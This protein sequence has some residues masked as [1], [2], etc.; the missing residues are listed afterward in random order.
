MEK[1]S[2]L[3]QAFFLRKFKFPHNFPTLQAQVWKPH[4]SSS[5]VD[6]ALSL[7]CKSKA[8]QIGPRRTAWRDRQMQTD[9]GSRTQCPG[10]KASC[11]MFSCYHVGLMLLKVQ[12]TRLVPYLKSGEERGFLWKT[13]EMLEDTFSLKAQRSPVIQKFE[14]RRSSPTDHF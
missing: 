8:W 9:P 12:G 13:W 4:S 6:N 10:S 3:L 1:S 2:H 11:E 14:F 7:C 5:Q